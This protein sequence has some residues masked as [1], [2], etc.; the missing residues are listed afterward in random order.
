MHFFAR[1]LR[2]ESFLF[3]ID[4]IVLFEYALFLHPDFAC[5]SWV[6]QCRKY[7]SSLHGMEG[8]TIYKIKKENVFK[9]QS[10]MY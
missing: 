10:K 5:V 1:K 4:I 9:I 3:R 7:A 6:G 8:Y 2:F